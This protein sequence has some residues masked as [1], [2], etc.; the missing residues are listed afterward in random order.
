MHNSQHKYLVYTT[1]QGRNLSNLFGGILK[2]RWFHKYILTLSDLYYMSSWTKEFLSVD[3]CIWCLI[4][5][6]FPWLAHEAHYSIHRSKNGLPFFLSSIPSSFRT[7]EK[8]GEPLEAWEH[9]AGNTYYCCMGC[10][11]VVVVSTLSCAILNGVSFLESLR[12]Y[13][14][15]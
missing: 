7:Q 12:L 8:L 15:L 2:N 3:N 10:F 14:L 11:T 13:E 9:I 6:S 1:F 5:L 4:E